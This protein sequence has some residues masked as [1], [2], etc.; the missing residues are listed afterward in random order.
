[1]KAESVRVLQLDDGSMVRLDPSE[2]PPT[3]KILRQM[4]GTLNNAEIEINQDG[5]TRRAIVLSASGE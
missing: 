2:T 4:K 5:K 3:I 1:M